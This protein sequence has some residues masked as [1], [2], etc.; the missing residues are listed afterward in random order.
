MDKRTRDNMEWV[1]SR[2]RWGVAGGRYHAHEPIYGAG[3]DCSEPNH[4]LRL[5]R[6]Y[7]VFRRLAQMQFDTLLDVGGA[8][9]YHANLARRLFSAQ[10]VTSDL[11]FEAN[12]RA[13]ELF[14]LPAVTSD[15]HWLPYRDGSFD[16]VLCCEVIEHVSDPVAVICEAAR[17][18]RRY[19]I[20]TTEQ[21]A[22]LT[23]QREIILAL[24]DTD[25]P[26]AELSWFLPSDFQTVLEDGVTYEREAV[27]TDRVAELMAAGQEVSEE[28]VRGLILDMTRIGPP[29][30]AD[31]GI[32]VVHAKGD[33]PSIDTSEEGDEHLLDAILAQKIVPGIYPTTPGTEELD[34]FLQDR[35]ACPVCLIPLNVEPRNLRCERCGR[36]YPVKRGIPRMYVTP[37]QGALAP[38]PAVR[39]PLLTWQ[40]RGLRAMFTAPRPVQTRLMCFFLHAELALLELLQSEPT[41]PVDCSHSALLRRALK[42]AASGKPAPTMPD[43]EAPWERLPASEVEV[44]VMR[45]IGA[46]IVALVGNVTALRN[47]VEHL[48]TR[49]SLWR[50]GVRRGLR[51]LTGR[52]S[53]PSGDLPA[54]EAPLEAMSFRDV[55]AD[56]WAARDIRALADAGVCRGFPDGFYR[57][58]WSVRRDDMACLVARVLAD[59][60]DISEP[61]GEPSFSDVPPLHPASRFV[62]YL[63]A[64]GI[65]LGAPDGLY[66]PEDVVERGEVT[67]FVSRALAGDDASVP[68]GPLTPTF[69]DLTPQ[70][71]DPYAT[72]YRYVEYLV[73]QGVVRGY[74]D[75]L[76]HP[77]Y[78]CSRAQVA[79][80]LAKVLE[81]RRDHARTAASGGEA[82][83]QADT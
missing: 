59:G 41:S 73:S 12:S 11:S 79:V 33:A 57:P 27:V 30:S 28:E 46:Y 34:P 58:N 62:E 48:R 15:A 76:Y 52:S 40:G 24:A 9:G 80:M 36:A 37:E 77:E 69:A 16:V 67:V 1:D 60:A 68:D 19:A 82:P 51:V 61:A 43:A 5:A 66:H 6:T 47:E 44:K 64:R 13:R 20:F 14:G 38:A 75:G 26:H 55:P 18:A 72:C 81:A 45:D 23:R 71:D 65:I 39:T 29:S 25:A 22:H 42:E 35:L 53:A 17:V 70:P 3:S 63:V 31:H 74:D 7:A 54:Q 8:E 10:V 78:P 4:A 83:P 49:P 21:V 32:L 2:Y 50:R 56:F